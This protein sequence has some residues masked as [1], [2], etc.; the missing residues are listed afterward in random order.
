M[1]LVKTDE[2]FN[3]GMK[4]VK[5]GGDIAKA[6]HI[7]N[8]IL[9]EDVDAESVIYALGCCAIIRQNYGL[10]ISLFRYAV[11]QNDEFSEAWNNLG[12]CY[13]QL[14]MIEKAREAFE[15]AKAI[16]PDP[17][18]LGNLGGSYIGAGNPQRA[19]SYLD[20]CLKKIPDHASS[21]NNK[22]LAYLELGDWQRGFALYDYRVATGNH[23]ERHYH[24]N[25]TPEWDGTPGKTVVVYGEQGIGDEIMFASILP[26][27]IKQCS[28]I[29]D[30]HPRLA[31]LFRI[32]FP[33]TPIYG[34]RK[35]GDMEWP[36]MY[37]IDAKISIGSLAKFY[38]FTDK[39]FPKEQYMQADKALFNIM[40]K[41]LSRYGNKP[42]I[43]ISWKGGTK[44]TNKVYRT[45]PLGHW[46]Y[47]L[48]M[49]FTFISLQYQPDAEYDIEK[50][51]KEN[52]AMPT[53]HHFRDI[54]DDYDKTAAL[55]ANLDLVIS[56]PQSVVHLAGAMGVTCWQLTPKRA[57]WQMG[58]YGKDMPWYDCVKSYWQV[59]DGDW[60][61]VLFNVGVDAKQMFYKRGETT[62][63]S[64]ADNRKLQT[65]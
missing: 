17:E 28:V 5:T 21:L 60:K 63:E 49:D 41:K 38:R 6:E 2:L 48:S 4:I 31:D 19:L 43:G 33:D 14:C 39:D 23:K 10:A 24:V 18:Y 65:A 16:K 61:Q 58:P 50:F 57:M 15:I 29:F 56:V 64:D 40:Q 12:C 7:F 36:K 3:Q 59:K 52:P 34:T 30:C 1:A 27:I 20:K 45:I 44:K 8:T 55:V 25:G 32:A 22:S 51:A 53:I 46:K 54:L 37:K 47:I 26:D 35:T 13:R 62:E 9:N 42:K 11:S